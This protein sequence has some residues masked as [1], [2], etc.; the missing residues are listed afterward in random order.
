MVPS[1]QSPPDRPSRPVHPEVLEVSLPQLHP[2]GC[3]S[4]QLY[5]LFLGF[6]I[7]L[8]PSAA[9]YQPLP[10]ADKPVTLAYLEDDGIDP[11]PGTLLP[12]PPPHFHL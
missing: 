5:V 2:L 3:L 6:S 8:V 4:P 10:T 12:C 7:P 9:E 1:T 11:L